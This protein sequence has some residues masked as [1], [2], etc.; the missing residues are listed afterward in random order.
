MIFGHEGMPRSGKSAEAMPLIADA[1]QAGRQVVTNIAGISHQF[2]SEYLAIPLPTVQRLLTVIEPP[3]DMPEEKVVDWVKA[4]FYA[5]RIQDSFWVWDEINQFWPP[6]RQP[7]NA[8]WAKFV[9][10]HGHKGID[11]L[12]MGQDLGELHKTW[13]ARLQR[14]TRFTKL[15]MQGKDDHMHWSA[16]TNIGR[17]RYKQT[18]AGKKPY[19]KAFFGAYKSHEDG[20]T[21]K[22]NY[23]DGRFSVFQKKHKVWMGLFAVAL[24][25]GVLKLVAFFQPKPAVPV[26]PVSKVAA[27]VTVAP[28]TVVSS[29]VPEPVAVAAPVAQEVKSVDYLDKIAKEYK[30]RLSAILDRAEPKPGQPA[31]DFVLEFLDGSNAVIERFSRADVVAL[32]WTLQREPYGLSISKEGVTHVVRSWPLPRS[33]GLFSALTDGSAQAV[34][35]AAS[36]GSVAVAAPVLSSA[37]V[38]SGITTVSD[39]E[40]PARPWH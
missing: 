1:L 9:T 21:N 13:R 18:A 36:R 19:N 29:P 15:D 32:G 7:L 37:P 8:D 31:F 12:I 2:F 11:I 35:S 24:V 27:P 3:A 20:T 38:G 25:L 22:A 17:G 16:H 14:Y 40:F 28:V 10:E 30:P 33:Q 6:D 26:A 23:Q 4:E 5:R 34:S 39:G